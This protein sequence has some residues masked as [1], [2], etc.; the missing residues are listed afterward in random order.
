[1]LRAETYVSQ[2]RSDV[3]EIDYSTSMT[4]LTVKSSNRS[5]QTNK[6]PRSSSSHISFL[7]KW[8]VKP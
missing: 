6:S 3:S 4:R 8:D 2:L 7:W 1:M 5:V